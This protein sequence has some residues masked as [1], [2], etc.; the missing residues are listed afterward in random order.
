MLTDTPDMIVALDQLQSSAPNVESLTLPVAWFGDDLRAGACQIM[1]GVEVAEKITSPQTWSVNGV[2][3]GAAH[4]VSRD[5]QDRPAYGGT[6]ADF[7]VV[8]AIREA[9]ARGLRVT[10]SPILLMDVPAGNTRPNPYSDTAAALGQPVYP[11]RGRITCSPSAGYAGSVDKTGSAESQ[12]AAFFGTATPAQFA[13]SGQ[14]V[15]WTGAAGDWGLRRM[16]LHYAHLC[17]TAGGVDTFLIGGGM[18]GL[19]TIRS[20]ASTYPAVQA[21]RA[22]AVDVRSILGPDTRISYAADWS[23]YFGHHPGDGSGDVHFYL[24]PLWADPLIDFVGIDSFFSAV[25]LAR[26]VRACRCERRLAGDLRPGLSAG[27]HRRRGRL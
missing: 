12:V 4:R 13:V 1:P 5:D 15:S 7:A 11:W 21:L 22:L 23:E 10:V 20:G 9:K 26:R 27:E 14:S 6:P 19:T 16:V 3:R 2:S 17:A 25:G 18:P 24:D 8:E